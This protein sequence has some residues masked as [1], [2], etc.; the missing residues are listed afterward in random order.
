MNEA[1]LDHFRSL[2]SILATREK[3]AISIELKS[4]KVLNGLYDPLFK[5][6]TIGGMTFPEKELSTWT[7]LCWGSPATKIVKRLTPTNN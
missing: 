4:G 7:R 5:T 3:A 1:A 6:V 2:S